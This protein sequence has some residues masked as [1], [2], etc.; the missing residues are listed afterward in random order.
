MMGWTGSRGQ[1]SPLKSRTRASCQPGSGFPATWGRVFPLPGVGF[2]RGLSPELQQFL[3]FVILSNLGSVGSSVLVVDDDASMVEKL[4][5]LIRAR[6][7]EVVGS[8]ASPVEAIEAVRQLRPEAILVDVKLGE[9]DCFDLLR[10]LEALNAEVRVLL[11]SSDPDATTDR[12]ARE[13]GA[14]GF[15]PKTDLVKA[16]LNRY[17]GGGDGME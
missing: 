16:D 5:Q 1:S 11:T 17:L 2:S 10:R 15:V 4:S 8:A 7:L 9:S 12:W 13:C 6:G 3:F 14:V